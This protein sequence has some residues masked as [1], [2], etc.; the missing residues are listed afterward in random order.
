MDSANALIIKFASV[1]INP[2]ILIMFAIALLVFV[3]GVAES[4]RQSSNPSAANTG[5]KHILYGIIGMV[6]MV[7]AFTLVN[8]LLSSFGIDAPATIQTSI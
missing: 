3:W 2:L 8:L 5:K 4:I 7:S 1:V 6:I